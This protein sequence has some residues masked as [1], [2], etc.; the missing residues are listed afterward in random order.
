MIEYQSTIMLKMKFKTGENLI[1]NQYFSVKNSDFSYK[2]LLHKICINSQ[3]YQKLFFKISPS[4][5]SF[6][7]KELKILYC[8]AVGILYIYVRI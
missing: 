7:E 4:L 8:T 1:L 2:P 6:P 5:L 3:R